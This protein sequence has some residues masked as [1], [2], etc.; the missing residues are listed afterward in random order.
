MSVYAHRIITYTY[1]CVLKRMFL[2]KSVC[3]CVHARLNFDGLVWD[4]GA[5][6]ALEMEVL[7]F[8]TRP[9]TW[10]GALACHA[11]ACAHTCKCQLI[12][13]I[14]VLG[15]VLHVPIRVIT[16]PNSIPRHKLGHCAAVVSG[17]HG[18]EC[19]HKE[20]ALCALLTRVAQ[21]GVIS[22]IGPESAQTCCEID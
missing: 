13:L 12:S 21:I 18:A 19:K 15:T 6:S 22:V 2:Y 16:I 11:G 3:V 20:A 9:S 8:C 5:S 10:L 7:R 1:M 4:C 17:A 14:Y